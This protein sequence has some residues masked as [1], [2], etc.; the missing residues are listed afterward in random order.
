MN[1]GFFLSFLTLGEGI[2]IVLL[3]TVI[4]GQ[5]RIRRGIKRIEDK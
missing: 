4:V 3:I 1:A 5:F 2:T